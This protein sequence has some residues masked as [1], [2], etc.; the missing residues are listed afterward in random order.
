M[1]EPRE[2][3]RDTHTHTFRDADIQ[4]KTNKQTDKQLGR[5]VDATKSRLGMDA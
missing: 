5:G 1:N 3:E 2:R 4:T